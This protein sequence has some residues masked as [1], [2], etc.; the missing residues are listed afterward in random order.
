MSSVAVFG[1]FL[2]EDVEV[3]VFPTSLGAG[4]AGVGA[5]G[6]FGRG[7]SAGLSVCAAS[8]GTWPDVVIVRW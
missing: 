8:G 2:L 4:V 6:A 7:V 1:V 3:V 5:V